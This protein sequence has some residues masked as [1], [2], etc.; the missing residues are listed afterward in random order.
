MHGVI[1]SDRQTQRL[2]NKVGYSSRIRQGQQPFK[3]IGYFMT[4]STV[5]WENE[6][7]KTGRTN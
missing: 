3:K 2:K 7:K 6:S 4:D 1:D 5:V